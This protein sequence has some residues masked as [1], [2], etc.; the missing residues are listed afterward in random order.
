[1]PT[2]A[3]QQRGLVQYYHAEHS[4]STIGDIAA[5]KTITHDKLYILN[6]STAG[7]LPIN[8]IAL[9]NLSGSLVFLPNFYYSA[10]GGKLGIY[11]THH[12]GIGNYGLGGSGTYRL[13]YRYML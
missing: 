2:D 13:N 9:F 6:V 4:H 8:S 10:V 11:E 1:M 5:V 3:H 7:S 12:I